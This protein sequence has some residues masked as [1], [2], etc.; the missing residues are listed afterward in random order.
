MTASILAIAA[1]LAGLLVWWLKRRADTA[2]KRERDEYLQK[3]DKSVATGDADS[4]NVIL[5]Q[6]LRNSN[7]RHP[8][9]QESAQ[10]PGGE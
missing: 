1:T 8:G 9:G 10:A 7:P 5:E 4:V 6:R 2:P 3:V